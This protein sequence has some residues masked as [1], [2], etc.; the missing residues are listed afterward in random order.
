MTRQE[1][2]EETDRRLSR[3][4]GTS[5]PQPYDWRGLSEQRLLKLLLKELS[6]KH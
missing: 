1:I 2:I 5:D 6:V 4:A 3:L